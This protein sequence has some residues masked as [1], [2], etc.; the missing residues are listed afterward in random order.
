MRGPNREVFNKLCHFLLNSP[1]FPASSYK[2]DPEVNLGRKEGKKEGR[3]EG[4]REGGR[5]G[6]R[7]GRE[8]GRKEGGREGRKE[9]RKEKEI[10][11]HRIPP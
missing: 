1:L 2:I 7:E 3:K 4:R 9:G 5:E 6:G 8:G 10:N 11:S